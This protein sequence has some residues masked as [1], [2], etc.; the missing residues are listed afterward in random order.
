MGSSMGFK[1]DLTETINDWKNTNPILNIFNILGIFGAVSSITSISETIIK[2]K[3]LLR[4]FVSLYQIYFRDPIT[5][6]LTH[7]NVHLAKDMADFLIVMGVVNLAWFRAMYKGTDW[8]DRG[9]R[10]G[11]RNATIFTASVYIIAPF[12]L[13]NSKDNISTTDLVCLILFWT[14][15]PLIGKSNREFYR[16][17]VTYLGIVATILVTIVAINTGIQG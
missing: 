14:A 5:E 9:E 10:L 15:F 17:Y 4:D 13:S 11:T 1:S 8:S 6:L 12:Y 3:G 16:N 7:I 2:W